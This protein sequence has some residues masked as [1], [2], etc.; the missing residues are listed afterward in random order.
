MKKIIFFFFSV[1]IL[2][3]SENKN[4]FIKPEGDYYAY[5]VMQL[6]IPVDDGDT[7][8]RKIP[9]FAPV[10]Q[11]AARI[12]QSDSL[13]TE[14]LFKLNKKKPTNDEL[15]ET[16]KNMSFLEDIEKNRITVNF[17][18]EEP[19]HSA[20]FLK[21]LHS[22]F[23][24][25]VYL[26][27]H[28]DYSREI[29]SI[30][31]QMEEMAIELLSGNGRQILHLEGNGNTESN[32]EIYEQEIIPNEKEIQEAEDDSFS[33]MVELSK[34]KRS[35]TMMI[36][37]FSEEKNFNNPG[38]DILAK[39]MNDEFLTSAV[40][41]FLEIQDK[42]NNEALISLESEKMKEIKR[43]REVLVKNLL[44]YLNN[45]QLALDQKI[46]EITTRLKNFA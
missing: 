17:F 21:K 4:E 10:T 2:A 37:F 11:F 29:G 24:G 18:D 26:W 14:V 7:L 44:S 40:R 27:F 6:N 31:N 45:I 8:L 3:C 35:V 13:L 34:Q 46:I 12:L 25:M 36:E 23:N 28:S 39:E 41:E 42:F 32:P 1:L 22:E 19:Q 38:M 15:N 30:N 33:K 5:A 9:D 43:K 20:D 16:K